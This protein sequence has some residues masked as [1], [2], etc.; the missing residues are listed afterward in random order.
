[1]KPTLNVVFKNRIIACFTYLWYQ[2]VLNDGVYN[3]TFFLCAWKFK[4]FIYATFDL[5]VGAQIIET[6]LIGEDI[7][8]QNKKICKSFLKI[9]Y[10]KVSIQHNRFLGKNGTFAL[11]V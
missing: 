3:P 4:T 7:Y 1:M 6:K 2:K 8:Q 11:K 5:P 10:G 9:K